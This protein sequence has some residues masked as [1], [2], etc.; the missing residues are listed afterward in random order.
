MLAA[1]GQ[2]Q[3]VVV[4]FHIATGLEYVGFKVELVDGLL[5]GA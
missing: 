2:V 1:V 3:L 4:E 5:S